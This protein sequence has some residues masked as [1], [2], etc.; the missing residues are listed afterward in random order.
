MFWGIYILELSTHLGNYD[1]PTN[2][3]TG[4]STDGQTE[5]Q[6]RFT[7]NNFI[8]QSPFKTNLVSFFS[9]TNSLPYYEKRII[10]KY[11]MK[12]IKWTSNNHRTWLIIRDICKYLLVFSAIIYNWPWIIFNWSFMNAKLFSK[13]QQF[14]KM[15][16]V[17]FMNFLTF[18]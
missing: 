1:G 3:T 18:S 17:N 5:S 10:I 9:R 13:A 11:Q 15:L 7:S 4:R 2:R 16:K 6:G 8:N 14:V 12:F